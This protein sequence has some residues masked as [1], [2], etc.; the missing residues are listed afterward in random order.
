[1]RHAN[2]KIGKDES[3][4]VYKQTSNIMHLYACV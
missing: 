2:M 4:N 3:F 1:M